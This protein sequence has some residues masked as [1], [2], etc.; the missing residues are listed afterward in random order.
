MVAVIRENFRFVIILSTPY[1]DVEGETVRFRQ[2]GLSLKGS[3]FFRTI[4]N[5][6]VRRRS[7]VST[8]NMDEHRVLCLI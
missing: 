7:R 3:P 5:V 4:I 6:E 8:E 2:R 1:P